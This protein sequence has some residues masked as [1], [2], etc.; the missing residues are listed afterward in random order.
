[1]CVLSVQFQAVSHPTVSRKIHVKC[2]ASILHLVQ[3]DGEVISTP[4]RAGCVAGG[5][6]MTSLGGG[7]IAAFGLNYQYLVTAE[8]FLQYLRQNPDLI[9]R[10]A[11]VVD[12]LLTQA[13][14]K[15]DDIVDFAIEV[16]DEATHHSQVKS[17]TE[18]TNYPLQPADARPVLE[19]L[20][21]H[22]AP[23]TFIL[24]NKPL[25][26]QL[27][28][29]ADVKGTAGRRIT[30]TW[31]AG[32]QS[33]DSG[34]REQPCLIVDSRTPAELRDAI[35]D[36]IR[37]FR[38]DQALNP[39][40]I[41]ARL[42]VPILQDHIFAA[43][44]GNEPNRITALD[45]LKKLAMPD[46]Q[47]A[48][49]AGAFDW[50]VPIGNIPNYLST[51]PRMSYL[52]RVQEHIAVTDTTTEPP[53]VVL[54]GQTGTG[55]SVI[56][57]DHCHVDAVSYEFMCW[58]DCREVDFIEPQIRNYVAQLTNEAIA[59]NAAVGSLFASLLARRPGPWLLVF[60]G[61][62]N[63][64]D[65]DQY[66]PTRGHGAILV[67]TNN[68]LNWWPTAHAIEVG[69]FTEHEAIDCFATYAGFAAEAVDG[70]RQTISDIVNRLG[71]LP[72]A[73]SMSGIYFKNTEG[74]L[75]EL[76]TQYFSDLTALADTYSKPPGFHSTAFAAIQHA[77]RSLGKGTPAGDVYGRRARAV[78]HIGSLLA[79]EVL[80]L[81]LILPA[82]ADSVVTDLANLP[83]PV[84]VDPALRRGVL[85]T[86]RT[87]TIARRVIN[88]EQGNTTP[89]S[90]TVAFHPLVHDILQVSYL[91][92]VPPGQL[93]AQSMTLM[94]FLLGWLRPLRASGEYF[95][96]EHLRLHAEA[97]LQ[98]VNE[99]E[100]LS[101]HS[102]QGARV[103][104][105]TKAMLQAELSTCQ[106]SRGRLQAAYDL[107]KEAAQN[108]S[109]Y[110]YEKPARVITMVLLDDIVKHLSMAEVPPELLGIFSAALLPAIHQAESDDRD[111]VRHLAYDVAGDIFIAINRTE[112]YRTSPLLCGLAE[113]LEHIAARDPSPESREATR[114][115][116]I[117]ELYESGQFQEILELLTEWRA[118]NKSLENALV[119]DGLEIVA[120][121]HTNAVDEA[122]H[123]VDRLVDIKPYGDH[124]FVAL[125]EALK[126][127]A[128]ELYRV[129][130]DLEADRPRLQEALSKVLKR[131][132]EIGESIGA[133]DGP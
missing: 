128:R 130:A 105:Y 101:S 100:P 108:L 30:Y 85:S 106:A 118:A 95:A 98:L 110:A 17:S 59:P 7:G 121:L 20:L 46:P 69:D 78:L 131:Y 16:D 132:N 103:Y 10:A 126:K 51:V 83:Q 47:I 129:S 127:V 62:Q 80:P 11:L 28:G 9:P 15:E 119:L 3:Q 38:K 33:F 2:G 79:P 18:P 86:L 124:L 102:P 65:I 21:S 82:T 112:V 35:A 67:T 61:I 27:L 89:A 90:E 53:R 113:Q 4:A 23:S 81:N 26:P 122:L 60:D 72:L 32:P 94:Y 45:M 41:S 55:K 115:K 54:V 34:A 37:G 71:R 63:R 42:L 97:L 56:A 76:A 107:G 123:G 22:Q 1:M 114:V 73:V 104:T 75:S 29:E 12:P 52:E 88:D 93:Q 64:S 13:D 19:R 87:Q 92:A 36:L 74:Q 5:S 96:V 58:I 125:F 70:L 109:A 133:N 68:S 116:R 24:T 31:P 48:H 44:A 120:Q 6:N 25:S 50:G 111:D 84:E 66:V 39:S 40:L 99:R 117:N 91:E 57:S 8:F 49:L 43:A 14:G 77:V